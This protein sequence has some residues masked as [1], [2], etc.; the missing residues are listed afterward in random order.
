MLN[1]SSKLR[2]LV[3][4]GPSGSGK[5]TLI[6]RVLEEYENKFEFS[7]SHTTRQPRGREKSGVE[8]YFVSPNEFQDMIKQEKL[9]EY[10]EFAKNFY[11]T[12]KEEINRIQNKNKICVLDLEINGVRNIKRSN[13]NAVFIGIRPPSIKALEERLRKRETDSEEAIRR[14]LLQAQNDM[15]FMN[16]ET[17]DYI[18]VNDEL[19]NSYKQFLLNIQKEY[20]ESLNS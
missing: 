16:E 11:G 1:T 8:Y 10:A 15:E 17:F 18:I 20:Q 9:L 14:R 3:V 6:N 5:S 13:L 2:P 19:G 12:S 4:C 7:I